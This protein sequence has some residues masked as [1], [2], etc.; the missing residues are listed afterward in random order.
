MW[1]EAPISAAPAL[2]VSLLGEGQEPQW[3]DCEY[4]L[5]TAKSLPD[6]SPLNPRYRLFIEMWK[7][8]ALLIANLIGPFIV[9]GTG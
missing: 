2:A 9:R 3:D 6:K 8:L 7:R 5:G 1:R 4:T